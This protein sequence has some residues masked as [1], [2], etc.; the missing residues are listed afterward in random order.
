MVSPSL[1]IYR[2]MIINVNYRLY[3]NMQIA[4]TTLYLLLGI[5]LF[6]LYSIKTIGQPAALIQTTTHNKLNKLSNCVHF[7]TKKKPKTSESVFTFQQLFNL[8]ESNQAQ[9]NRLTKEKNYIIDS[10]EMKFDTF[11][12]PTT[13]IQHSYVYTGAIKKTLQVRKVCMGELN[14]AENANACIEDDNFNWKNPL[15]LKSY[16]SSEYDIYKTSFLKNFKDFK[17][18]NCELRST[19]KAKYY[20]VEE[21]YRNNKYEISFRLYCKKVKEESDGFHC[22]QGYYFEIDIAYHPDYYKKK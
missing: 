18:F 2:N 7:T 19:H 20:L 6:S 3:F 10:L 11:I 4:R 17:L 9:I 22:K 14:N 8:I 16:E 21:V 1:T 15:I 12:K 13:Q 5:L